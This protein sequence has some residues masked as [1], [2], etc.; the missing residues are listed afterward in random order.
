M[1]HEVKIKEKREKAYRL[2]QTK[3]IQALE[4]LLYSLY[5]T[6]R[7]HNN[8][9]KIVREM[10]PYKGTPLELDAF[11]LEKL[12]KRI[13]RILTPHR[14]LYVLKTDIFNELKIELNRWR[15][16]FERGA[17]QSNRLQNFFDRLQ[18]NPVDDWAVLNSEIKKTKLKAQKLISEHKEVQLLEEI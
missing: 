7:I 13:E 3:E 5:L 9:I 14:I 6:T 12:S 4:Q 2:V 1:Q 18:G 17:K 15:R 16:F 8:M 11:S 10:F